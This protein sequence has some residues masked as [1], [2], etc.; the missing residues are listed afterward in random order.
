MINSTLK[1]EEEIHG[2]WQRPVKSLGK[3][4]CAKKNHEAVCKTNRSAMSTGTQQH[5]YISI[6][7]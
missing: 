2:M 1:L 6:A 4:C 3:L 5:K 7:G